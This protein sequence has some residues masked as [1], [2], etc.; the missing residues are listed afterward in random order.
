MRGLIITALHTLAKQGLLAIMIFSFLPRVHLLSPLEPELSVRRLVCM[1]VGGSPGLC[2]GAKV[3]ISKGPVTLTV[4]P[5]EKTGHLKIIPSSI[6]F[7]SRCK[8]LRRA[9]YWSVDIIKLERF[10]DSEIEERGQLEG[11]KKVQLSV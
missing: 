7:L 9:I 1:A 11:E 5:G 8:I 4:S 6:L 2:P 10:P 3:N